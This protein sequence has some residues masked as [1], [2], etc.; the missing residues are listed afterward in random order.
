MPRYNKKITSLMEYQ[1]FRRD[2]EQEDLPDMKSAFL[3]VLFFSGCRVS[4]ALA[5]TAHDI[6]CTPDTIYITFFRLKGSKQTDPIP[7]P[8]E[9]F[10]RYLCQT[11]GKLFPFTRRTAHR[12]VKKVFSDLYP[13]YFRMNRIV[14][15]SDKFGDATV[16]SWVGICAQSIDHYRGKVDIKRVAVALR[17]EVK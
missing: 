2:I 7:L 12:L 11:E 10:L 15:I 13:H 14:H 8:R 6:N 16:Y 5:L 17:E 3:T 4:E 9:S 1:D